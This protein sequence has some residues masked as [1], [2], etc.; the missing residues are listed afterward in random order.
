MSTSQSMKS[1]W[2]YI[3]DLSGAN[4]GG[5]SG[6]QYIDKVESAIQELT[7]Q[8]NSKEGFATGIGQLKGFVAEDWHAGT[9]NINAVLRDS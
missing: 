3:A 6:E 1:G 8:L 5:Q 4:L 7:D 9:F 2:D